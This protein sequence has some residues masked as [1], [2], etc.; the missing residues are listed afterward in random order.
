MKLIFGTRGSDL[1]L[2][3]TQQVIALLRQKAPEVAV[4]KKIIK[5][6]GDHKPDASLESI[7]GMGAF[8]REIELA[9]L[10]HT[11]D[12]AVHSLK[13]LPTRQPEGLCIAAV[14]KRENPADVL[15]SKYGY[16]LDTLP[17]GATV[18]TSSLRRKA[19]L[20]AA[21]P[22]LKV[23]ELRGNVPTRLN[24]ARN[25]SF[26]A[27]VLAAA[28]LARLG[29]NQEPGLWEIPIQQM[30]PAP[31]Q[32][33][34]ALEIRAGDVDLQPVLA[35]LHDEESAASVYCER[36]VL[37]S[38]GGGCRS[39]LGA[40][41]FVQEGPL[42]LYAFAADMDLSHVQR[43]EQEGDFHHAVA[44]GEEAGARLQQRLRA[45][46]LPVPQN[47][48]PLH[49]RRIVVT[50][51]KPQAASFGN[52]LEEAGASVC[53]LP[54]IDI[55]PVSKPNLPAS[56]MRFDWILFTSV[57]AVHHFDACLKEVGRSIHEYRN[58]CVAAIGAATASV[59]E[60]KGLPVAL[61]PKQHVAHALVEK[62]LNTETH[63]K[64]KRVLLPQGNLAR[65]TIAEEL[66]RHGMEVHGFTVYETRILP[67]DDD[68]IQ[69]LIAF[70][71]ECI[72]FFSPSAVDAY[73]AVGLPQRLDQEGIFLI[74]ASIGPVTG[75]ALRCG[76]CIPLVEAEQQNESSL[77]DCIISSFNPRERFHA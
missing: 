74:H 3:Q 63:P 22:D 45:K 59:L 6:T 21:R 27:V 46:G 69:K 68:A 30:L 15:A 57:N 75:D 8:T 36:A 48:P 61:M 14:P 53:Y 77:R 51:A 28:G 24:K 62:I 2:T 13:D 73:L 4:E 72:V 26:D 64:G 40:Y 54:L 65:P 47:A 10:H 60:D 12:V 76:H 1:A 38:F 5:T 17:N 7:S 35:I 19:Q 16:T 71:P 41:A 42:H 44:M 23:V 11:I 32:G 9:L 52:L 55:I 34:L 20:L 29:L 56:E 50:R 66:T 58:C 37:Q 31:G 18:G 33:A 39:P 25:G 67:P 49:G 70:A 43:M